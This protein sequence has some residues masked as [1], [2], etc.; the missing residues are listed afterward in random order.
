MSKSK[1]AA[2]CKATVYHSHTKRR[3][4]NRYRNRTED[5]KN[6]ITDNTA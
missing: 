1:M 2:C 5:W 6:G 3:Y 4:M